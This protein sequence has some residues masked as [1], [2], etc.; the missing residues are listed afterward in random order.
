MEQNRRPWNKH[1][2]LP[3][4]KQNTKITHLEKK[5]YLQQVTEIIGH[6]QVKEL[7]WFPT[8]CIIQKLTPNW[9][10]TLI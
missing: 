6:P 1:L 8:I 9:S 5:E 7:K 2:H 10:N 3:N 4:F